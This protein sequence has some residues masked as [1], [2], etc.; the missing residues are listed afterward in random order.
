[1]G[2]Q[3]LHTWHSAA[4]NVPLLSTVSLL[5]ICFTTGFLVLKNY[6][7]HVYL[8]PSNDLIHSNLEQGLCNFISA[9]T[10]TTA[11]GIRG[12]AAHVVLF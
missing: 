7:S 11:L 2:L 1:M 12:P 8:S 6:Y 9:I 5:S 10:L 3:D 4:S